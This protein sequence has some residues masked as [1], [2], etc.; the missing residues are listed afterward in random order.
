MYCVYIVWS[1]GS[2]EIIVSSQ[3]MVCCNGNH[4]DVALITVIF[5]AVKT[6][7]C[8]KVRSCCAEPPGL[9]APWDW[10][11]TLLS[12]QSKK[13]TRRESGGWDSRREGRKGGRTRWI[14]QEQRVERR[15]GECFRS[16]LRWKEM[17]V[18]LEKW[19]DIHEKIERKMKEGIG[20]KKGWSKGQGVER[21]LWRKPVWTMTKCNIWNWA[22]TAAG[23][24]SDW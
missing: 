9:G 5:M 22:N 19:H 18:K 12:V 23:K 15:T 17:T 1:T 20:R 6:L 21:F 2:V 7:W 3:L 16:E 8:Y 14:G 11:M 13:C 4:G 10:L 24:K